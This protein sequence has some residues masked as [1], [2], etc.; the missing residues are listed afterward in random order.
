MKL[1]VTTECRAEGAGER[2]P[3][4]NSGVAKRQHARGAW[5]PA[6][7]LNGKRRGNYRS[8][9]IGPASRRSAARP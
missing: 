8:R 4:E 6:G 5:H 2:N 7:V 9:H 1:Y 3:A